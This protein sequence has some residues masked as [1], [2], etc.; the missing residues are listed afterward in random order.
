V[1]SDP[2]KE[3]VHKN[4]SLIS[5]LKKKKKSSKLNSKALIVILHPVFNS[6]FQLSM[7]NGT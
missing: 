2:E 5:K 3:Q 4:I 7:E 1:P 6:T